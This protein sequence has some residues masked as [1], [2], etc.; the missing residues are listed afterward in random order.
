MEN[1]DRCLHQEVGD[2]NTR[3]HARCNGEE[4]LIGPFV[5]GRGK[6][7]LQKVAPIDQEQREVPVAALKASDHIHMNSFFEERK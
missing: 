1:K 2:F 6:H 3:L 5:R 4:R 7:F